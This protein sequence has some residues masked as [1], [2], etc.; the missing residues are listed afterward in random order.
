MA[1]VTQADRIIDYIKE[2]G[3]ITQK[4]AYHEFDC[5]RLAAQIFLIK[6]SGIPIRRTIETARNR[7]GR[8]VCYARYFLCE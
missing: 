4:E 8:T 3:S 1:R 5:T 7:Y 2:H 6:E